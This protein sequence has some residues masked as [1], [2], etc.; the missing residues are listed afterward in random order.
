V[1]L[2]TVGTQVPFDRLIQAVD[3]ISPRL[4][5]PAFAQ[6]GVST[7]QP[8][9]I[10][11]LPTMRPADFEAKFKAASVIVAH[12]G[13]GTVLGALRHKKP[14]ILM[15][16]RA[17]LGEHRNDHQLATCAQLK[18]RPGIYIA[19]TAVD[20]EDLLLKGN[21][22]PPD[23]TAVVDRRKTFADKLGEQLLQLT[24]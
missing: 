9:H 11:Y 19:E 2:A 16:R 10:D 21:L 7:Y 14:I 5:I 23:E 6:I 17:S 22:V 13:I 18:D 3:E 20:L 8:R 24:K 4:A 1:I 12:A 15:P